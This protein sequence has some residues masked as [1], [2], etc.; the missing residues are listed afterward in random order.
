M[1]WRPPPAPQVELPNAG[2][3]GFGGSA[4]VR[5]SR[6]P[7]PVPPL[8]FGADGCHDPSSLGDG[9]RGKVACVFMKSSGG[10]TALY[11][12]STLLKPLTHGN[13]GSQDSFRSAAV[14]IEAH[15]RMR[16]CSQ[17]MA[18]W[19]TARHSQTSAV[20]N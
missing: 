19:R 16:A 6:L 1:V 8:A 12:Y 14:Q 7:I 15:R 11:Q 10:I 4:L 3:R 2:T 20:M 13:L 9:C 17:E 18:G 5:A